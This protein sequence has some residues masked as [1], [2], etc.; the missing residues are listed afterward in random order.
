MIA[1]QNLQ[2][3]AF[4]NLKSR[5]SKLLIKEL[6]KHNRFQMA[7]IQQFTTKFSQI[8]IGLHVNCSRDALV[9]ARGQ[10]LSAHCVGL[11]KMPGWIV[12]VREI[13]CKQTVILVSFL[14]GFVSVAIFDEQRV[15]CLV[16]FHLIHFGFQVFHPEKLKK[17][18]EDTCF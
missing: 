11:R 4:L 3:Y 17:V 13:F 1:V 6:R 15:F 10:T 5:K 12:P 18:I 7:I 2:Y 9:V 14:P 8:L 16:L